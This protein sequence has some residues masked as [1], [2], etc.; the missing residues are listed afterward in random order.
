MSSVTNIADAREPE[1][2]HIPLSIE[3]TPAPLDQL[4]TIDVF[5]N[6]NLEISDAR[7]FTNLGDALEY[8]AALS[9]KYESAINPHGAAADHLIELLRS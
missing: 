9:A 7:R 2:D 8:A 4:H 6:Q 5:A 3:V 1:R